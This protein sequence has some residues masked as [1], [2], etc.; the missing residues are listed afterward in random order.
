MNVK[1]IAV[2]GFLAGI[3]ILILMVVINVLVNAVIPTDMGRYGGMRDSDDLVMILFFFYPF[4]VAFT[5]AILF[6]AVRSSLTGTPLEKGLL[7]GALLLTIMTIPSL[8]VMITSMTWP[9]DFYISTALWEIISFPVMG[10]LFI[11]I[12]KVS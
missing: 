11:K 3:L 1:N 12:W 4:V 5:A 10:I 7:F 2:S 9:I 8:Y 6:D